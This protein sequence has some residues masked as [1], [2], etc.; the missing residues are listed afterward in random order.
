MILRIDDY[1]TG[2]RPIPPNHILEFGPI[3][4]SFEDAEL[5]YFLGIVPGLCTDVD[6]IF[7]NSL[8]YMIPACH[9]YNHCYPIYFPILIL[10]NDPYNQAGLAGDENEFKNMDKETTFRTIKKAV[11]IL[12]SNLSKKVEVFIPPFNR[13]NDYVEEALIANGI[14]FILSEGIKPKTLPCVSSGSY[15]IRSDM[16]PYMNLSAA[17]CVT[18]HL[19]W[20]WDLVRRGQSKLKEFIAQLKTSSL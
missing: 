1:P 4:R 9:G 8:R 18:L 13:I 3:L 20:E 2:V 11:D 19:T 10:N 16:C 17:P 12:R 14:N 5:S 15:Y 7:L 6:W